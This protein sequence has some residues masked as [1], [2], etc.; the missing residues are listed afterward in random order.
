MKKHDIV[1]GLQYGDEGKGKVVKDLL[2]KKSYTHC[3]RFNG[4]PNAGHTI[5]HNNKKLVVHQIPIGIFYNLINVLGPC[6]VVNIKKL[7]DEIK[8][9]NENGISINNNFYISKN[10][11][12]ILPE[13]IESDKKNDIVGTTGNGIAN[14]YS[15]KMMRTGK[16]AEDFK[17]EFTKLGIKVID[18]YEICK[19]AEKILF[20]GAQGFCLDIDFGDYPYVTSST[21]TI[22]GIISC[23]IN[24]AQINDTYGIA[25][26]YETY[27]GAKKFQPENEQDLHD[28]QIMGE[29]YGATTGRQRQCNWI[30][31]YNL[32]KSINCNSCSHIIF[33][34]CDIIKKIN[35]FKSLSPDIEYVNADKLLESIEKYI[36]NNCLS[37]KKIY[38]SICPNC[39]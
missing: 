19:N 27:V 30:N 21:C 17:E 16:R 18:I 39:I 31:L 20:E 22:G 36:L 23:G 24:Y 15:A 11:H 35:K 29:E 10:T 9:L 12:I 6:C 2:S 5:Y 14:T 8:Y 33:N 37:V 34:K 1:V 25:K 4:G 28:L 3:I 32:E 7:E 13:Y 38:F 26:P